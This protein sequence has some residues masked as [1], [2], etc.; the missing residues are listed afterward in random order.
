MG[1]QIRQ[2]QLTTRFGLNCGSP[3]GGVPLGFTAS[4]KR[5]TS[6]PSPVPMT[7]ASA[8]ACPCC[9]RTLD[10]KNDGVCGKR[11]PFAIC[12]DNISRMPAARR[13]RGQVTY[14][15]LGNVLSGWRCARRKGSYVPNTKDKSSRLA[16]MPTA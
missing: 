14:R 8:L 2:G 9:I 10:S 1:Q 16:P 7:L 4:A 6:C 5:F 13:D 11:C 15:V 3:G 12:R